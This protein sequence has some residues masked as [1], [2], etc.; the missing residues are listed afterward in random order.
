[1]LRT[2]GRRPRRPA[3][4]N[5]PRGGT[6]VDDLYLSAASATHAL[7]LP[8][9]GS[10]TLGW[11]RFCQGWLPFAEIRAFVCLVMNSSMVTNF[12]RTSVTSRVDGGSGVIRKGISFATVPEA[13]ADVQVVAGNLKS[14]FRPPRTFSPK[15]EH[16]CGD[17]G[18]RRI[19]AEFLVL[20]AVFFACLNEQTEADLASL[21]M[22]TDRRLCLAAS[23]LSVLRTMPSMSIALP[24]H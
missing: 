23:N 16:Y 14:V 2:S 17:Y 12:D 7:I 6:L 1:M 19:S 3:V 10:L 18:E 15:R 13:E 4:P 9:R 5:P 8:R 21:F 24:L 22:R 11:L 20:F